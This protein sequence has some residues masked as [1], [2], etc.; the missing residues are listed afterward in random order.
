LPKALHDRP[1]Y[2]RRRLVGYREARTRV[3]FAKDVRVGAGPIAWAVKEIGVPNDRQRRFVDGE[4]FHHLR[5]PMVLHQPSQSLERQRVR[6]MHD[7]RPGLRLRRIRAF[8]RRWNQGLDELLAEAGDLRPAHVATDHSFGQARL[9]YLI[10]DATTPSEI[11]LA[12]ADKTVQR[13]VLRNA[14]S[15]RVKHADHCVRI[16]QSLHLPDA[17]ASIPTIL[18][19]YAGAARL[20]AQREFGAKGG[21]SIVE[22]GVGAPTQMA[23]S[24]EHLLDAHLQ[25]GVGVRA[26]PRASLCYLAEQQIELRAR[27][28]L[29]NWID[30]DEHTVDCKQLVANLVGKALIVDGWTRI[31]ACSSQRLEHPDEAAVLRG[32]VPACGGVSAREYGNCMSEK[33]MSFV[34]AQPPRS[35]V[36]RAELGRSV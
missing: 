1:R 21:C 3:D 16:R 26:H 18:L 15:L 5:R 10:D 4:R 34:H 2:C 35:I 28:A 36:C 22:V 17:E 30:P 19:E 14:A 8:R 29:M 9:K 25:Y 20:Q 12:T 11:R 31:D 27:L 6:A 23:R 24:I 32:G 13:H 33:G 7:P